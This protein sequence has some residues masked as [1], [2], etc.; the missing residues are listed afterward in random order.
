MAL[1]EKI[2][3]NMSGIATGNP[4]KR[5]ILTPIMALVFLTITSLFILVPLWIEKILKINLAIPFPVNYI[6][7]FIIF[8]PGAILFLWSVIDF[9]ISKG[10]PAPINPPKKLITGGPYTYSR[11]PMIGGIFMMMFAAGIYL[12]SPLMV[13]VFTPL[14]MLIHIKSLSGVEEPELEKR[15]GEEYR[16][17]KA[18]TPRFFGWK[19]RK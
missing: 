2:A 12:G 9:A 5:A 4:K 15:F 8:I 13:F 6:L 14:Y 17:Y 16:N 1:G 3:N 11:N 10:T 19:K 18:R 7:C